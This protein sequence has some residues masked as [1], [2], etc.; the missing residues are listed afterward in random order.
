RHC[1]SGGN[2]TGAGTRRSA[3][4]S[5]ASRA[6]RVDRRDL[7]YEAAEARAASYVESFCRLARVPCLFVHL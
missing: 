3:G 5:A 6:A 4:P 2:S 7:L 1:T